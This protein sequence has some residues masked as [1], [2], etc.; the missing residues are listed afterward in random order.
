MTRRWGKAEG[1]DFSRLR[2]K[3]IA[4]IASAA[5]VLTMRWPCFKH[6]IITIILR[7]VL[8]LPSIITERKL[9]LREVK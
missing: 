1:R 9:R 6:V 5:I 7:Q 2:R 4:M 8:L 3:A